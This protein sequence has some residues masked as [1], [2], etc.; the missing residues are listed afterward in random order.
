VAVADRNPE[1]ILDLMIA[2]FK[3]GAGGSGAELRPPG[4]LAI[5]RGQLLHRREEC[6]ERP[7]QGA[8][9]DDRKSQI[10]TALS[11]RQYLHRNTSVISERFGGGPSRRPTVLV[12]QNQ[13]SFSDSFSS[14]FPRSIFSV[15]FFRIFSCS[16]LPVSIQLQLWR[17]IKIRLAASNLCGRAILDCLARGNEPWALAALEQGAKHA[18]AYLVSD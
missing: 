2:G 15:F 7:K 9:S 6:G 1:I 5:S 10:S 8:E 13:T 17:R 18:L 11:H 14:I 16:A 12:N 3:G 4:M